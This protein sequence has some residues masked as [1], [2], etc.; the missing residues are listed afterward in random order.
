MT[1][2]NIYNHNMIE[3]KWQKIWSDLK[4]VESNNNKKKPKRYILEMFPYPSGNIHMGH[5]RNYTIGDVIARFYKLNEFDVLH[6]MG[7]D[8]F[9][10]PAENAAILNKTDPQSWTLNNIKNMKDQLSRLGLAIDWDREISTS[11]INYY[12]HQQKIFLDFYNND[13]VYKKDSLVNWDPV[14]KT[15]LANEQVIDGKGWRSGA[16]VKSKTLSQWFFK[17]SDFSEPLLNDLKSLDG[18][19]EKVKIM[20][21]NWIGKSV[22]LEIKFEILEIGEDINVFT[23]RP[24]TLYGS[25]FIGLSFDH[26]L[27]NR[28]VKNKD[29]IH[30]KNKTKKF[31]RKKET[32]D[33][34]DK[35]GFFT[36][37]FARHPLT[38]KEIPIYFVN[39]VLS[40]YG[41]G[42]IFGCPAH[43]QRDYD[44]ANKF[45]LEIKQVI[46]NNEKKLPYLDQKGE[47]I[48]SDF[49]NGCEI[50]EARENITEKLTK[51]AKGKSKVIYRL[52]DWGVSR[53][54]YWGCP[55][56]VVYKQNGDIYL[57]PEK[58]LPVLLP[59]EKNFTS[60]GNSLENNKNWVNFECKET[61][62]KGKRE[63]DTLDTFVDSSWY[64]LRFCDPKNEKKIFDD[65]SIKKWMPVDQYIGGVEHAILHL[66]YSRF[67][68]RALKKCGYDV[69]LEPFKNLLT[70]GMVNHE[71]YKTKKNEWVEPI[72][73]IKKNNQYF[74]FKGE[75]L[76][77]G[78][79]EKMS[80]SKKNIIDPETIIKKYGADT[81]RFFIMSDS[82]PERDLEWSDEGVK[83]TWKFLSKV[84]NY[85]SLKKF[86]F[87]TNDLVNINF[88]TKNSEVEI[89][90]KKLTIF[91]KKITDDI[92]SHRFNVAIAKLRELANELFKIPYNI[93]ELH[94]F[95][96]SIFIRLIYP[97][98]P[99]FSEELA[100][101]G[102][103]KNVSISNL[104]WPRINKSLLNQEYINI[105]FQVNGKKK[106][107]VNVKKDLKQ[108]EIELEIKQKFEDIKVNL[109]SSKKV[110]FVKNKIINFVL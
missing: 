18:W 6:P 45:N 67:F 89:L 93:K 84:F 56:P 85:L 13:L 66:L 49:I 103:L 94:D 87:Y 83:A 97:F 33:K 90:V 1:E 35:E 26:W 51:I 32:L 88:N 20:Q 82:P 60:K 23:T 4:K 71:T 110:I 24:E 16:D 75:I 64:F 50:Q 104:R 65:K 63:T 96:W 62:I 72:N 30:F 11:S 100:S 78:R 109:D 54:R 21:S 59:N 15:V 17:I 7:W 55:I 61:G 58:D 39:Y 77:K 106:G 108:K 36:D 12:K 46:K 25:S 102:N 28:F 80:K 27:S 44:F 99:H 43:D 3:K 81:A 92:E 8:S 95:S 5:V 47:M 34:A 10:M 70:Q 76:I 42:A 2:K 79:S 69:P 53:Q 38:E 68:M 52:K 37:L 31:A 40:D 41:S 86:N 19:P 14:D 73:V 48:N 22:G 107:L 29:F 91:V 101:V 98:T 74:N 105:V 57:V 9:G